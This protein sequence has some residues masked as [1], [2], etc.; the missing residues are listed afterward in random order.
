MSNA[1]DVE[2]TR[3]PAE[4][5]PTRNKT[6]G[7]PDQPIAVADG[8][9]RV[10]S[11]PNAITLLASPSIFAVALLFPGKAEAV[12]GEIDLGVSHFSLG[13]NGVWYQQGHPYSAQL[14]VPSAGL[15]VRSDGKPGLGWR[16]GYLFLGR[17]TSTAQA[18]ASD[19]DYNSGANAWPTSTYN[20]SGAVQGGYAGLL[21]RFMIGNVPLELEGGAYGYLATWQVNVPDWRRCQTCSPESVTVTHKQEFKVTPYVGIALG[22]AA[23]MYFHNVSADGD[24]FPAIYAGDVVQLQFRVC[25]KKSIKW[26]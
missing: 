25:F 6:Q 13:P 10:G 19:D 3:V 18:S 21:Y 26:C 16:A 22:P 8:T 11:W 1:V 17:V 5:I 4:R 7:A 2:V 23:L 15:G 9:G 14:T 20:G 12:Q 24:Q